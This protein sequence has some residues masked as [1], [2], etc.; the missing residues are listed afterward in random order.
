MGEAPD[1]PSALAPVVVRGLPG[2]GK[3]TVAGTVSDRLEACRLRTD[4]VN[5][6]LFDDPAHTV[7][8]T[9]PSTT[10]CRARPRNGWPTG[11]LSSSTGR[12]GSESGG[13]RPVT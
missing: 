2:V 5:K 11:I 1:S 6:E 12:S 3:S 13:P 9:G 10:N 4:V 7:G 8:E